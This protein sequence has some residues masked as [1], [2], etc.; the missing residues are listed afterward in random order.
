MSSS[1]DYRKHSA[2]SHLEAAASDLLHEG[3]KK[4][5]EFYEEGK[6][7]AYEVEEN[8]KDNTD[9]LVRKIQENPLA[10]VL[11]AGGIGFLLSKILKK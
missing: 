8:I 3:K 10:S 4:V 11:I 5:N 9:K 1:K 2:K 6:N 7:K